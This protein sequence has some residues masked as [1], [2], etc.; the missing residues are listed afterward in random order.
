[1]KGQEEARDTYTMLVRGGLHLAG[2]PLL[3]RQWRLPRFV[4]LVLSP[5]SIGSQ[6]DRRGFFSSSESGLALRT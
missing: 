5:T 6:E 1:M 2:I 4:R 3:I